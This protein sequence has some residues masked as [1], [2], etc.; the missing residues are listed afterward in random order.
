MLG[1]TNSACPNPFSAKIDV[2]NLD[3]Y[4]TTSNSIQVIHWT[5]AYIIVVIAMFSEL[6]IVM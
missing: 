3:A 2:Y 6:F 4:K 5:Y 1:E